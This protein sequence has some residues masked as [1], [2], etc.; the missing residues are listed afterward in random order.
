MDK[1]RTLRQNRALHLF[2][3]LLADQLNEAGLDMKK[4]LKPEVDI[5]WTG[6]TIKEFI[7][8][9]I[10]LAQL[11]KESTTELT[12]K[13][14]DAVFLTINR[15]LGDKFG[16]VVDFPSVETVLIKQADNGNNDK[17]L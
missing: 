15:H 7:W 10:M 1:Q 4:T 11:G 14:I 8:R 17:R 12:T 3:T 13:D 5:P 2:F 16:L 9:P 6:E